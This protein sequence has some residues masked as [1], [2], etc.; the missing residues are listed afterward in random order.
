M[1][2]VL[3]ED[4]SSPPQTTLASS[5]T[6]NPSSELK[7]SWDKVFS[8]QDI[9]RILE[10]HRDHPKYYNG[11]REIIGEKYSAG[12]EYQ[13]KLSEIKFLINKKNIELNFDDLKLACLNLHY[14]FVEMF[15]SCL[16]L[17]EKIITFSCDN[18]KKTLLHHLASKQQDEDPIPNEEDLLKKIV[19]LLLANNV[20][21][22]S[23]DSIN[24]SALY[25][26]I[27]KNNLALFKILISKNIDRQNNSGLGQAC[28]VSDPNDIDSSFFLT[29]IDIVL[30]GKKHDSS[31]IFKEFLA[32]L[33][34]AGVLINAVNVSNQTQIKKNH[35]EIVVNFFNSSLNQDTLNQDLQYLREIAQG[36]LSN[37]LN[38]P[39]IAFL[40][41]PEDNV[42]NFEKLFSFGKSLINFLKEVNIKQIQS[43]AI[44]AILKDELLLA[45]SYHSN[46]FN[47]LSSPSFK[48]ELT[49]LNPN[50]LPSHDNKIFV[51]PHGLIMNKN[52]DSYDLAFSQAVEYC[53]TEK[54]INLMTKLMGCGCDLNVAVLKNKNK[55]PVSFGEALANYFV[56]EIRLLETKEN[57][58]EDQLKFK[59]L[60]FIISLINLIDKGFNP[61]LIPDKIIINDDS[62]KKTSKRMPQIL[63][64]LQKMRNK[65]VDFFTFFS[66]MPVYRTGISKHQKILILFTIKIQ[67]IYELRSKLANI[68]QIILDEVIKDSS[69]TIHKDLGIRAI[70]LFA[71][72][73]Q[74]KEFDDWLKN[75]KDDDDRLKKLRKNFLE[76]FKQI[77]L[78][79]A[80]LVKTFDSELKY[81]I[82]ILQ[83]MDL[84]DLENCYKFEIGKEEF[85]RKLRV[86]MAGFF[87]KLDFNN[88]YFL[89]DDASLLT[90]KFSE[91]G[92]IYDFD[93]LVKKFNIKENAIIKEDTLLFIRSYL[94]IGCEI[95]SEDQRIVDLKKKYSDFAAKAR[96]QLRD[97]IPEVFFGEDELFDKMF[98]RTSKVHKFEGDEGSFFETDTA[99]ARDLELKHDYHYP[100]AIRSNA[101]DSQEFHQS[102]Q[103]QSL[104]S[105]NLQKLLMAIYGKEIIEIQKFINKDQLLIES[106]SD[107]TMGCCFLISYDQQSN[108]RIEMQNECAKQEFVESYQAFYQENNFKFVANELNLFKHYFH[109]KLD[110]LALLIADN[111]EVGVRLNIVKSNLYFLLA[112]CHASRQKD[113]QQVKN[114]IEI[115]YGLG[116]ATDSTKP[117]IIK[118]VF[119]LENLTKIYSRQTGQFKILDWIEELHKQQENKAVEK[120]EI[121]YSL[122]E[123][124]IENSRYLSILVKELAVSEKTALEPIK[125][126][127]K[128]VHEFCLLY[129]H[130]IS[131]VYQVQ[132]EDIGQARNVYEDRLKIIKRLQDFLIKSDSEDPQRL[133]QFLVEEEKLLDLFGYMGN[134][135][136]VVAKEQSLDPLNYLAEILTKFK[137]KKNC[138]DEGLNFDSEESYRYKELINGFFE[139]S[140]VKISDLRK[141]NVKI[142]K[143]AMGAEKGPVQGPAR[144]ERLERGLDRVEQR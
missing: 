41:N 89:N 109:Q 56:N 37:P 62:E 71:N 95:A 14:D 2:D 98:P 77:E 34:K 131:E 128:A 69:D 92:V 137:I 104:K 73:G 110:E 8:A 91:N 96:S 36:I 7:P 29:A 105:E 27:L 127:S 106:F 87:L 76:E 39:T 45:L 125:K 102:D 114:D 4:P 83:K 136:F 120:I 15:F 60:E 141:Q 112:L 84:V 72:P 65:E 59:R 30:K 21:I 33:L 143:S 86:D 23:K 88:E 64:D 17:E 108:K 80:E 113:L 82:F 5:P 31:Y 25:Y 58:T 51:Y 81:K 12:K 144:F 44:K 9:G 20:N 126:I 18:K 63:Q 32:P 93:E 54:K 85:Q 134:S 135:E 3:P 129:C 70:S 116:H 111:D 97:Y 1:K 107:F 22:N 42:E 6:L 28:M 11:F 48:G 26:T 35:L 132:S 67:Y 61:F 142:L 49:S 43:D 119:I 38:I 57:T 46:S 47:S 50:S 123:S 124:E 122:K 75:S 40:A 115:G 53:F 24:K 101:L 10:Y 94:K 19:D 79:K 66:R 117:E 130:F 74:V 133:F 16:T 99:L 118:S 78:E 140:L 52:E 139:N 138:I 121:E 103:E 13:L 55:Q 90:F 100:F 68:T